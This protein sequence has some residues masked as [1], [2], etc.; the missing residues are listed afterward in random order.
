[1]AATDWQL[2]EAKARL[3]ELVKSAQQKGPQQI[4][5]HGKPAAV[6]L[7]QSDYDRLTKDKPS[8]LAFMRQSAL[9]GVKLD[10]NVVS[11]LVRTK[12]STRVVTWFEQVPDE[13]LHLSVLSLGEI[14]KGVEKLKASRRRERLRIWL[15]QD[16]VEWLG[17]RL[18]PIDHAVADRWGILLARVGRPV[19][20]IDSLLAAAGR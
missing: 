5:V 11:E 15:E 14:R 19:P 13:A 9:K 12:P 8:F 17:S 16:L 3:S 20:A 10:T 7:S 2:Q 4:T 1:M 18:L 6:M